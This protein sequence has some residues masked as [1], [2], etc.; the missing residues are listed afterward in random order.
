MKLY[1]RAITKKKKRKKEENTRVVPSADDM[2]H[3]EN[4][5]ATV[6]TA[7]E[8]ISDFSKVAGCKVLI[9]KSCVFPQADNELSERES[10][11]TTAFLITCNR[12]K[13]LGIHLPKE[14]K[15]LH[16]KMSKTPMK[17]TES[18]TNQWHD[19]PC[20]RIGKLISF[21]GSYYPRQ[22]LSKHHW[23]FSQN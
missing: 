13:Y 21:K 19:S 11:D 14:V 5:D 20:S 22:F 18:S 1:F 4:P 10:Q 2:L 17:K 6:P 9:Q 23:H 12:I 7:T 15:D 8:L 16:S 3:P